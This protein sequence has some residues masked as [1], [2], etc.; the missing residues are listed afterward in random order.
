MSDQKVGLYVGKFQPFHS[1]HLHALQ[2]SASHVDKLIVMIGSSQYSGLKNLPFSA[3]KR[4]QMIEQSVTA[5]GLEMPIIVEVPDIDDSNHW[6]DH[7]KKSMP[8]FDIVFT[9]NEIVKELFEAKNIPVSPI[10]FLPGVS[11]TLVRQKL[12]DKDSEWSALVPDAT[13]SVVRDD[14][15]YKV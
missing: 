7:V 4:R 11:G 14:G 5:K 3:S 6:V 1:G 9:N 2:Y 12:E 13:A 15:Q 8:H 10:P